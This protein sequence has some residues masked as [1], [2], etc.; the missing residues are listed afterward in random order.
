MRLVR[1]TA[2]LAAVAIVLGACGGS[3][4]ADGAVEE[5]VRDYIDTV[6]ATTEQMTRDAFAALPPG[7]APTHVQIAEV[8]AARRTALD[9]IAALTP[10]LAMRPEHQ[11]LVNAMESFV[12]AGEAFIATSAALDADAFLE[13]LEA[14]TDIDALAD[15]VS[16]SCSAWEARAADLGHPVELGC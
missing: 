2:A 11:S 3:A 7:A 6:A 4:G 16:L 14:S 8:V 13:A 9:T 12:L 5:S 10:P 15:V 1:S